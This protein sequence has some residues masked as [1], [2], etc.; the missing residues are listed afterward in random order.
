MSE[1]TLAD[2]GHIGFGACYVYFTD[3]QEPILVDGTPATMTRI[4]QTELPDG[5]SEEF[6]KEKL[7]HA[8]SMMMSNGN[9]SVIIK[10]T[11]EWFDKL[12]L[13]GQSKSDTQK[14]LKVMLPPVIKSEKENWRLDF[15]YV[16]RDGLLY[17]VS[18][19]GTKKPFVIT[20][21]ATK[22]LPKKIPAGVFCGEGQDYSEEEKEE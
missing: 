11:M 5:I 14:A 20:T 12:K 2:A 3:K 1:A 16:T 13:E 9:A 8:L 15:D 6:L 4:L 21:L 7:S 10:E 19:V 18:C 22:L 17:R